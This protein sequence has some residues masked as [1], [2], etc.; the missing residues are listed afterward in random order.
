MLA[1]LKESLK[2]LY[3]NEKKGFVEDKNSSQPLENPGRTFFSKNIGINLGK[4]AVLT[5]DYCSLFSSEYLE[6]VGSNVQ[7]LALRFFKGSPPARSFDLER[8]PQESTS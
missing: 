3:K 1:P 7:L 5:P 4:R 2:V 8:L 6:P